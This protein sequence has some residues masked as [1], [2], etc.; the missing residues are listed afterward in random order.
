MKTWIKKYIFTRTSFGI[1]IGMMGGFAYYYF[2]GCSSGSCPITSYPYISVLYG[3]LM[4]GVLFFKPKKRPS[5]NDESEDIT[6][7]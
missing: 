7:K 1:I 6:K 4:G 3:A 5:V 2:I